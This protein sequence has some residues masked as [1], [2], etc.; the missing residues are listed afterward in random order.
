MIQEP[1]VYDETF[2]PVLLARDGLPFEG[3][4]LVE[5]V[6]STLPIHFFDDRN[7]SRRS[8]RMVV[9]F[10]AVAFDGLVVP[11]YYPVICLCDRPAQNGECRNWKPKGFRSNLCRDASIALG[12]LVRRG[13]KLT[14]K[15]LFAGKLFSAEAEIVRTD[16]HRKLLPQPLWH[17]KL[18]RLTG[19]VAGA[20]CLSSPVPRPVRFPL[21]RGI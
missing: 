4:T 3:E 14:P 10:R 18:G 1:G 15:R 20:N 5:F 6:A 2:T 12:R 13:D 7:A 8:S 21:P 16:R 9:C 17:S 19:L 11:R